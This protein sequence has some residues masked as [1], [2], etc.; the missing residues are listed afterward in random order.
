MRTTRVPAVLQRPQ[1]NPVGSKL[2]RLTAWLASATF[3]GGAAMV[4]IVLRDPNG[5]VFAVP[6][7]MRAGLTLWMVHVILSIGLV[8]FA[9]LAPSLEPAGLEVLTGLRRHSRGQQGS[10]YALDLAERDSEF[11]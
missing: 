3:L 1:E 11:R 8:I 10:L 4:G 7:T 6:L 9:A 2:A 5:I